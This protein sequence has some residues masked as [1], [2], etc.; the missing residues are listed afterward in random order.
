[1]PPKAHLALILGSTREGRFCDTVASWAASRIGLRPDLSLDVIDP[2]TLALPRRHEREPG[3]VVRG[4]RRRLDAADGFV[5]VTPE[6]N[7][8]YTAALK[9]VIDCAKAEWA[10][11]PVGFVSYGGIAGGLRAVEQL[12]PVFAELHAVTMRDGVS[13]P[14][15]ATLFDEEGQPKEPERPAKAMTAMLDQLAWWALALAEARAKRPYGQRP[16]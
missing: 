7:H 14:M 9:Q 13:F 2:L 16:A 8:G 11:K 10:A 1:M 4:L 3:P 6:Y 5:V 12:R 15:A